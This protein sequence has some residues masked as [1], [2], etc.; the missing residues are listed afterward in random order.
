MSREF[1][2]IIFFG[3]KA[4]KRLLLLSEIFIIFIHWFTLFTVL[5]FRLLSVNYFFF[6]RRLLVKAGKLTLIFETF[7]PFWNS[8]SIQTCETLLLLQPKS[9]LPD[10]QVFSTK[11]TICGFADSIIG[12][13]STHAWL[14][15]LSPDN[16][17]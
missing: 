13:R 17:I 16:V 5:L 4:K 8:L 10:W 11:L 3:H 6:T 2:F 9:C 7:Q 12:L 15:P 14:T 1:H